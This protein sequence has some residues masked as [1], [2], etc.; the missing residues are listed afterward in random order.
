VISSNQ[1]SYRGVNTE[2]LTD[3]TYIYD[4]NKELLYEL[5]KRY[6]YSEVFEF[7]HSGSETKILSLD[8]TRTYIDPKMR[9]PRLLLT[10]RAPMSPPNSRARH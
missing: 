7:K 8:D 10:G 5:Q 1:N 6:I 2:V 4:P 9:S 3:N